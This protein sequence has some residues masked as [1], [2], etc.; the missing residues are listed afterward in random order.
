MTDEEPDGK[1]DA[2]VTVRSLVLP[3]VLTT[4]RSNFRLRQQSTVSLPSP[5]FSPPHVFALNSSV[6][7]SSG[8]FSCQSCLAVQIQ[9]VLA[10]SL[11]L[12]PHHP[13]PFVIDLL[14]LV[15]P[16]VWACSGKQTEGILRSQSVTG[17]ML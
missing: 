3:L 16:L 12:P 9:K 8:V 13:S 4:P 5:F 1:G 10:S 14:G 11:P 6:L 7:E 2:A 15:S 17:L